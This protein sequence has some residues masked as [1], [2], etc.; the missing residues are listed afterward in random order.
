MCNQTTPLPHQAE[1]LSQDDQSFHFTTTLADLLWSS[2][3]GPQ[4]II[5][6]RLPVLEGSGAWVRVSKES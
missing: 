4:P 1:P 5:A 6:H 3:G 2:F